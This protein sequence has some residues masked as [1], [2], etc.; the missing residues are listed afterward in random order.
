M[1]RAQ[2]RS[3][4]KGQTTLIRTRQRRRASG[5][6]AGTVPP[7][8]PDNPDQNTSNDCHAWRFKHSA[9][10]C[11]WLVK[12][13]PVSS[14]V[15]AKPNSNVQAATEARGV[16]RPWQSMYLTHPDIT[17]KNRKGLTHLTRLPNMR[18]LRSASPTLAW[19]A[20]HADHSQE[21]LSS[22]GNCI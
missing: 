15:Y 16:L 9:C 2:A 18:A 3:P 11:T 8:R 10:I 22:I 20:H 5:A 14:C 17:S 1:A 19:K 12:R 6:G 7:K 13:L 4:Q 21:L